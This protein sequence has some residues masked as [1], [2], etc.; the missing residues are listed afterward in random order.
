LTKGLIYFKKREGH[1]RR[2]GF[3]EFNTAEESPMLKAGINFQNMTP[4]II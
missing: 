3:P 2:A 4:N 1:R